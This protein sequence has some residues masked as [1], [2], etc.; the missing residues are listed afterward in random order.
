M[1]EFDRVLDTSLSSKPSVEGVLCADANGLL[2]RAKGDISGSH[3]GKYTSIIRNASSLSADSSAPATVSIETAS[4]RTIVKDY[5]SMTI[6]L[7]CN[8]S[9]E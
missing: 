1:S 6:V 4:H 7:K 3:A 8:K 5:E 2:I 9:L